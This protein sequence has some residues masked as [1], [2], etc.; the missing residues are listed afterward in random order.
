VAVGRSSVAAGHVGLALVFTNVSGSPCGLFGYPGVA[1]LDARGRQVVQGTRTTTGYL[2]GPYAVA[3]VV[4]PPGGTASALLEGT[5]V[6]TGAAGSCAT[7]SALLVT[8]PAQ[9]HS[10]A[11]RNTFPGCSGIQ[12]HPV[13]S[14]ADGRS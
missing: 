14:G 10:S 13:V 12:V 7:Y 3:K 8:P 1:G 2:G 5:D 11:L 6:P 4:V 9:T